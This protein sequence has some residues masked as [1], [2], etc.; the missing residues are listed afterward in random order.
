MG[1]DAGSPQVAVALAVDDPAAADDVQAALDC[2]TAGT[3]GLGL[4]TQQ[5]VQDWVQLS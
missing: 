2:L 3:D 1:D 4:V 5:A